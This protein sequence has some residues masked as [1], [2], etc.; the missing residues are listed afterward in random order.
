MSTPKIITSFFAGAI[1]LAC[2]SAAS[3]NGGGGSAGNA[4]TNGGLGGAPG[5][6]AGSTSNAGTAASAGSGA[7]SG[8]GGVA[9]SSGGS[10]GASGSGTATAGTAGS[11]GSN[12]GS[13][14]QGLSLSSAEWGTPPGVY[15]TDYTYPTHAEVDR[16][17]GLKF[18]ILRIPFL[19]ERLQPALN[20]ELDATELGRLDD[21]VNYATQKGVHTIVDVH[22][23]ARYNG[24]VI[25]TGTVTSANLADFWSKLS[26]H[27]ASN[28]L[29]LIG[30]MNEPH[31]IDV[32][33]W[34]AAANDSI[35][36]IRKAGAMNLILVPGTNWTGAGSW[37]TTNTAML[38]VVDSANNYAYEVHLYLDS[39]SSGSHTTCVSATIGTERVMAFDQWLATNHRRGFLGEFGG[40]A[41]SDTKDQDQ[42][43]ASAI[44]SLLSAIESHRDRWLGWTY[45]AG[46]PWWQNGSSYVITDSATPWQ[47]TLLES[48]L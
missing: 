35:A 15:G 10:G 11:A 40:G 29:V 6:T 26:A 48:H 30:L 7:Q 33:A 2:S 23:Y 32:N 28:P 12:S 5:S 22:N 21:V 37:T 16:Y 19:W 1:A 44:D 46:G 25:G 14:W 24:V 3:S 39:D 13:F 9:G 18:S 47:L 36:A 20:G 31:D 38:G 17:S 8:A 27:Y 45:W 42:T 4:S 41:S 34:L 43:C